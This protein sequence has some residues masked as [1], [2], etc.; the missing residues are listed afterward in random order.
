M[1]KKQVIIANLSINYYQSEKLDKN[2]VL[3]FLH[4][5]GSEAKH[6]QS[7]FQNFDNFIAL[8]WPG[9]GKSD[10]PPQNWSVPEYENLLKKFLQKLEIQNPILIGHSFGGGMILK[11]LSSGN[12]AKKAI[13]ISPAGIRKKGVKIFVYKIITKLFK[14][15]FSIPGLHV[16][17]KSIRKKFY[18]TIDSED[19]I[20]AG[21][22]T[23]N[24]KKIIREDLSGDMKSIENDISLIWGEKD[25]AIP[26]SQ[27]KL[28]NEL[29]KNSK[30]IIIKNAGHF[31][32]IHQPEEFNKI[33]LKEINDN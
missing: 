15:I 8:D 18:K 11:Y 5:W 26:I 2:E 28:M 22:L 3:V 6:L 31:S 16:F 27:G 30:L 20:N 1:Q 33:F 13:L 29:I 7:I 24:Y 25:S 21:K 9:F 17:K 32:F 10:F 23:E 14:A 12:S 4:G 19:Y